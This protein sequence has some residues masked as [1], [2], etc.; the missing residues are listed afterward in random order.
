MADLVRGK[1]VTDAIALL[2]FAEKKSA[3]PVKKLVASALANAKN[4]GLNE[5]SLVVK[6][7]QVNP[8]AI[9]YRRLSMSRGR[10]FPMRKRTSHIDVVL[11]DGVTVSEVKSTTV[12]KDIK[13]AK[14]TKTKKATSKAVKS[15]EVTKK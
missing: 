1:K 11:S 3:S 10:A 13:P 8:G 4:I 12:E 7:I 14:V 15:E 6:D 5:S 2:T 9:L